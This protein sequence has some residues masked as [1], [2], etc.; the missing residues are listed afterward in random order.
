M[1]LIS[2]E[3]MVT[4]TMWGPGPW[5]FTTSTPRPIGICLS[6]E[7]LILI[8]NSYS[9]SCDNIDAGNSIWTILKQFLLIL[10]NF[11]IKINKTWKIEK[12]QKGH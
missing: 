2:E 12:N 11:T 9:V 10:G 1:V 6:T 3:H 7:I 8:L 4:Y 5:G